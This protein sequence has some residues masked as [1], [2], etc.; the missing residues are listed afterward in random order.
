MHNLSTLLTSVMWHFFPSA[1]EILWILNARAMSLSREDENQTREEQVL[2]VCDYLKFRHFICLSLMLNRD[3][4]REVGSC[5]WPCLTFPQYSYL[6][7]IYV[8]LTDMI[9]CLL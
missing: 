6:I 8:V 1:K 5:D 7:S 9:Y 4:R 3:G 2:L